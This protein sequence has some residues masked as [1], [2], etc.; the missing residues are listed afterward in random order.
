[1][2]K[3]RYSPEAKTDLADIKEYIGEELGNP[4]AA[5]HTVTHITKRI[6][7][8]PQPFNGRVKSIQQIQYP[9]ICDMT[10]K[11]LLDS[12]INPYLL[13]GDFFQEGFIQAFGNEKIN[14]C[15]K[16]IFQISAETAQS[17]QSTY[18][19]LVNAEI[20]IAFR[21]ASPLA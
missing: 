8:F 18:A 13:A 6:R 19:S 4:G 17:K 15:I 3:I 11:S 2:H 12:L 7:K 16:G 14:M 5:I 21:P 20:Q 9:I 10:L 1:M